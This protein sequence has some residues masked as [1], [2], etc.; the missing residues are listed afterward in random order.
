MENGNHLP[1]LTDE[2]RKANLARA[3][4][5]RRERTEFKNLVKDGALSFADAIADE[6]A[7]RI[8]VREILMSVPGVGRAKAEDVMR[9]LGIADNRRVQGL[10]CRQ[11]ELI[12][13]LVGKG[14]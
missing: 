11:R 3:A 1:E 8:R 5:A 6:R 9:K 13:E 7:K 14:K 10:G 2:Q 4:Q 12:I